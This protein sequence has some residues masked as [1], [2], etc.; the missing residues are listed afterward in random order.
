LTHLFHDKP[1]EQSALDIL[2]GG[3]IDILLMLLLSFSLFVYCKVIKTAVVSTYFQVF[4]SIMQHLCFSSFLGLFT[5]IYSVVC[6]FSV[7]IVLIPLSIVYVG[8]CCYLHIN[9]YNKAVKPNLMELI[10]LILIIVFF[11]VCAG[12][13]CYHLG[14]MFYQYY[15]LI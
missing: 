5:I 15:H 13:K 12:N 11:Y 3:I 4:L 2:A 6:A 8:V 1:F 9:A 10:V 14:L 7:N